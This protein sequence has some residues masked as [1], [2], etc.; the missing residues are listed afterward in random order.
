MITLAS[1]SDSKKND[2]Q[3]EIEREIRGHRS[4]SLSDAIGQSGAGTM[5]GASPIPRSRQILMDLEDLLE[6]RLVDLE[7]SLRRVILQDLRQ[8]PLIPARETEDP[9]A[10]LAN[11]IRGILDTPSQ[12][13]ELVRKADVRWGQDYDERPIFNL[14]DGPSPANPEN[15]PYTPIK[16]EMVLRELLAQL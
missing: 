4:F 10:I 2:R 1:M 13:Q 12:L 16:V 11:W 6:T 5:K 14:S 9:E 8:S 15:D 7:G 3:Q